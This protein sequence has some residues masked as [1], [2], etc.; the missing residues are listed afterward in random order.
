MSTEAQQAGK[1]SR[2]GY[3]AESGSAPPQAFLQGLRELG[4]VEDKNIVFEYR[5][6]EGKSERR[7]D[8]ATEIVRLKVDVIVVSGSPT[9]EAAKKATSAVPIVMTSSSDPV[10]LGLVASLAR[11]GG[12]VTGLASFTGELGGKLLELLKEVV[13]GLLRVLVPGPPV[14]SPTE[15]LFIKETEIPAR[16]LKVQVIRFPV[17][18]PEDFE[19]IFRAASKERADALLIRLPEVAYSPHYKRIVALTAKSRLPAIA[20]TRSWTDAG[21]LV[22]YGPDRNVS[23]KRAA[24]FVDKILKGAKPADLPVEQPTKFEFVINLNAAKQ[25][26]LTIPPNVLVRADRV[27]K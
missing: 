7:L 13:P 15:D 26:G 19:S 4:Y 2:I 23:L 1:P 17:R 24:I 27:I 22:S 5:T 6:T 12:N 3:L 8:L 16:A 10:G 9:A 14:G 11:P 18:G 25:I 20:T 21:G